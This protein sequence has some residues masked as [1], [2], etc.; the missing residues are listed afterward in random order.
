MAQ[1]AIIGDQASGRYIKLRMS[2]GFRTAGV[3]LDKH[4][5]TQERVD[6]MIAE[7]DRWELY[8]NPA[9]LRSDTPMNQV[10]YHDVG[11]PT[12]QDDPMVGNVHSFTGDFWTFPA[13]D[14]PGWHFRYL[15]RDGRW[16]AGTHKTDVI[17]PLV[18]VLA[19]LKPTEYGMAPPSDAM[20]LALG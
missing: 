7:G 12:Q 11:Q 9:K 4:Y 2:G 18:H 19:A 6:Q 3:K 1:H 13:V 8:S 20:R 15:F 14:N 16:W 10:L 5:S 17:A